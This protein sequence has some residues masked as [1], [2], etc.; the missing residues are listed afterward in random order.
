MVSFTLIFFIF[1][2][3]HI[4]IFIFI[5]LVVFSFGLVISTGPQQYCVTGNRPVSKQRRA[6][7]VGALMCLPLALALALNPN[8]NKSVIVG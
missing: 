3:I 7:S 1:L 2:F 4:Y 6:T 8:L 5:P